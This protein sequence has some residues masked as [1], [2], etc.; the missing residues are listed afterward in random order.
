MEAERAELARSTFPMLRR[1]CEDRGIAFSIV[2]LRWGITDE[3]ALD[4]RVVE[5]CLNEVDRCR[6]YFIGLLGDR[7]GWVPSGFSA[8]NLRRHPWLQSSSGCS[9]TELEIRHGVL[10]HKVDLQASDVPPLFY[11]RDAPLAPDG[12][13]S[14]S[15]TSDKDPESRSRLVALKSRIANY[16]RCK[17]TSYS[18]AK[19]L[20]CAIQRDMMGVI[21]ALAPPAVYNDEFV[22]QTSEHWSFALAR[23]KSYLGSKRTWARLD[24][25]LDGRRSS[26]L[27]V[28]GE[29]I[30]KTALLAHWLAQRYGGVDTPVRLFGARLFRRLQTP[31]RLSSRDSIAK[32]LYHFAGSSSDSQS[33][34]GLL[35]RWTHLLQADLNWDRP[36]ADEPRDASVAFQSV[37]RAQAARQPVLMLVDGIDQLEAES[38]TIDDLRWLPQQL[39]PRVRLIATAR[40]ENLPQV[41]LDRFRSST[42]ALQELSARRRRQL[43]DYLLYEEQARQLPRRLADQIAHAPSGTGVLRPIAVCEELRAIGQQGALSSL[44]DAYVSAADDVIFYT[45]VLQRLERQFSTEQRSLVRRALSLTA[46]A[47]D[48]LAEA[49]LADLVLDNSEISTLDWSAALSAMSHVLVPHGSLMSLANKAITSAVWQLWLQWPGAELPIRNQ[50]RAYFSKLP[51]SPRAIDELPWQLARLGDW[52]GLERLLSTPSFLSQAWK[53]RPLEVREYW[54]EL[55]RRIGRSPVDAYVIDHQACDPVFAWA[56]CSLLRS[57]GFNR[58]ALEFGR[59]ALDAGVAGKRMAIELLPTV[60]EMLLH[61]GALEQAELRLQQYEALANQWGGHFIARALLFRAALAQSRGSWDEA[62]NRLRMACLQLSKEDDLAG[63]TTAKGMIGQLHFGK[64]QYLQALAYFAEQ[65]SL[66]EQLGNIDVIR[67]ANASYNG[68]LLVME[69]FEDAQTGFS[70]QQQLCE[71]LG[72][73]R[74]LAECLGNQAVALMELARFDDA[75]HTLEVLERLHAELEDMPGLALTRLRQAYLFGVKLRQPA[76]ALPIAMKGHDLANRYRLASLVDKFDRLIAE[77]QAHSTG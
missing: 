74:G 72:D 26:V 33:V 18:H 4:G 25:C 34:L 58:Q 66:S 46:T 36:L 29:G 24:E 32:W 21:D 70:R 28:G 48:G 50:L 53:R 73:R 12:S 57:T 55:E 19:E 27:I 13:K 60:I 5:I 45:L 62:L 22:R 15:L 51:D 67:E 69:R 47:R 40:S 39:P 37:L 20:A 64:H 42:V 63:L 75:M 2:D 43:I 54:A 56:A 44:V 61:E 31:K 71:Q 3:Q 6:P 11:V 59:F 23:S 16:K 1:M 49:E 76:Y 35:R 10:Q 68:T 41:V 8:E 30:G 17:I 7:Y 14:S 38:N 52:L 65:C 77:L 9:M